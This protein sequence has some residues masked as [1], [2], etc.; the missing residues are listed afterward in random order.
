MAPLDVASLLAAGAA[1]TNPRAFSMI[2]QC[3]AKDGTVD[4]SKLGEIVAKYAP[5]AA[6]GS[7]L[8]HRHAA[9]PWR[10]EAHSTHF[11]HLLQFNTVQRRWRV[12]SDATAPPP[13]SAAAAVAGAAPARQVCCRPPRCAAPT[14]FE[15]VAQAVAAPTS[16]AVEGESGDCLAYAARDKSGGRPAPAPPRLQLRQQLRARAAS[17]AGCSKM[18]RAPHPPQG[19]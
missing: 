7:T 1:K 8:V 9:P 14:T 19:S 15:E 18:W 11:L 17:R 10:R 4:S 12:W 3:C 16:F 2:C 5:G 13:A 6:G